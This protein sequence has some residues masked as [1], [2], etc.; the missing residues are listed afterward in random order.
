MIDE[1]E[2]F[3]CLKIN[4]MTESQ[5]QAVLSEKTPILLSAS[6]GS[7]KTFVLSTRVI[8]KL[9]NSTEQIYP[10]DLLV[11]TFAKSA[12]KEMFER[13]SLQMKNLIIKY[14]ND[15][16]LYKQYSL[17]S[18]SN[19]T[20]IDSFCANLLREKFE[21]ANIAPNFRI[22]EESE[23]DEIKSQILDDIFEEQYKKS[24][25]KFQM[26]CDY[27]SLNDDLTL[28]SALLEIYQKARTY[29]FPKIYLSNIVKEYENPPALD[30]SNWA[31]EVKK[32]IYDNIN[33]AKFLLLNSLNYMD[34]PI[35]RKSFSPCI[36]DIINQL[37][38]TASKINLSKYSE[39]S[40]IL[41]LIKF[42]NF[43]RYN[44]KTNPFDQDLCSEIKS[45]YINP[46]KKII[47]SLSNYIITE[48][49]YEYDLKQQ[50]PILKKL[51]D[52]SFEF[53][54]RIDQR[55]QKL[56]LLEFSDLLLKSLELLAVPNKNGFV[57][58][59]TGKEM[60][61]YFKEVLVDEFQDV[62]QA[63]D[64][65]FNILSNNG[66]NLFM[67][68]D[69]KQSIYR[70]RQADPEV[71]IKHRNLYGKKN[72]KGT[73]IQLNNN[74]RSQKEVTNATNFLFGQIMTEDFGGANYK[75]GE[76][77]FSSSNITSNE[78]MFTEFHIITNDNNEESNLEYEAKH[79]AH[80]IK[81]ML[82]EKTK[83]NDGNLIRPCEP[84]DFAILFRSGRQI[85]KV[86]SK[87]L[88][89][90]D[91]PFVSSNDS[92]YLDSYE[93]SLTISLLKIINNPLLDIPLCAVLLSPIFN[94][95][96]NELSEIRMLHKD[97]PL[98]NVI[99]ESQNNKCNIFIKELSNFRKKAAVLTISQ[100]IQEIYNHNSFYSLFTLS[101]FS[102]QNLYNLQLL[103]HHAEE[104][105]QFSDYGLTG[106]LRTLDK[107]KEKSSNDLSSPCVQSQSTNAVNIM[108]IHK[109]KGLEFP[110][111]FVSF[112]AKK[113]NEKDFNKPILF[114]SKFGISLKHSN[115]NKFSRY[116]TLQFNAS[117]FSEKNDMKAEELRL[118]Y[119][120]M[121][122]AKNKLILT[123]V[124]NDQ[125]Y[126]NAISST[127]LLLS[128]SY[129]RNKN[130]FYEWLLDGF[131]RH[132]DAY[133]GSSKI[134][135]NSKEFNC[136]IIIKNKFK[137][138]K[139]DKKSKNTSKSD[140][141][142]VKK[143]KKQINFKYSN[144]FLSSIPAKLSVT[145]IIKSKKNITLKTPSFADNLTSSE[146]GI[147]T[148][149]FLQ[150]ANFTN[151]KHNIDNEITRLVKYEYITLKQAKYLNIY[152]LKCFFNSKIYRL[153]ETADK[154]HREKSFIY[155]I[156]AKEIYPNADNS[157]I[158]I[159]GIIDCLIEKN[160]E[161]IIVDYKTD[162]TSEYVLKN[163]YTSQLFYYKQ[164]LENL[165][166]KTVIS[167]FIYSVH[168]N[169]TIT[170]YSNKDDKT[171]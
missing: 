92:G 147:A 66:K 62:N 166:K 68:G 116:N 90:L 107:Y 171:I 151:A 153:I 42:A 38:S 82:I 32:G 93:V 131:M 52:L 110:I 95:S 146:I 49:Q 108:T 55:K 72:S 165:T 8:F 112:C 132:K 36:N 143:I 160:N 137:K 103:I 81:L 155:E 78:D 2:L 22:A 15:K 61:K 89:E 16:N 83:I 97:K 80:K 44:K 13:I 170:C 126:K 20:T 133:F 65:L 18:Q 144:E 109:S 59:E 124:D 40:K 117:V 28:K 37:E 148:H 140:Y 141:N 14:P 142:I 105:E 47:S 69:I 51:V 76:Q 71:F 91:I 86:L 162:K 114:S 130:S 88:T 29:P 115:P 67:V 159:Q 119:V 145:D 70:F 9:L 158:I 152:K 127:S 154:I 150:Y 27:F 46:A 128:S 101:N 111:V 43:P 84:K 163:L 157:K 50:L 79:I 106:F 129:C 139:I 30:K 21:L 87:Y 54:K 123:A 3:D 58:T 53:H 134:N 100:L 41:S 121:T 12:A 94:F 60:S 11:V 136:S 85:P 25:Q 7:G 99:K 1:K 138:L 104:Y 73:L 48:E 17:L 33:K 39:I 149:E 56:N 113:F 4:L 118:L 34:D 125:K 10:Q 167:C 64:M 164:A 23:I 6:A 31:K 35:L 75:D 63:Q 77:L 122:R 74:F 102:D 96:T 19:I 156:P 98:Y 5:K 168:L 135:F 45:K 169:K 26:L 57:L 120:G 161:L 24:P